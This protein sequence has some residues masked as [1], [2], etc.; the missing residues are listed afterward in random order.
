LKNK[1]YHYIRPDVATESEK[2]EKTNVT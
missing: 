2:S 1:K